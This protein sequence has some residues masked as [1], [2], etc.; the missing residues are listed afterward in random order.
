MTSKCIPNM[1]SNV[2]TSNNG[3]VFDDEKHKPKPQMCAD[4]E[5]CKLMYNEH[6]YQ[7]LLDDKKTTKKPKIKCDYEKPDTKN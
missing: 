4:D 6:N 5:K 1:L 7:T 2:Q 3:S